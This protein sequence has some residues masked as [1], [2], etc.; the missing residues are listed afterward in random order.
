MSELLYNHAVSQLPLFCFDAAPVCHSRRI[1]TLC[2][3][4]RHRRFVLI[5]LHWSQLLCN[6]AV[7][8]AAAAAVL[9]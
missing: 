3:S 4:C 1:I 9:L 6:Y 7:F 5:Q 8:T 2:Y